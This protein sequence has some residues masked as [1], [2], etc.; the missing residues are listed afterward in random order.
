MKYMKRLSALLLLVFLIMTMIPS[1]AIAENRQYTVRVYAGNQGAFSGGSK[2]YTDNTSPYSRYSQNVTTVTPNKGY[3]VK[4]I[5]ES[6]KDQLLGGYQMVEDR[7]YVVAYGI[8]GNEVKYT[9]HYVL[10]GSETELAPPQTFY[11]D[12]GD[13]PVSSYIYIDG[14]QPYRRT[15]RTI[16]LDESQNVLYAYYT[17]ITTGTTGGGG[18]ITN[19]T[20]GGGGVAAGGNAAN[21]NTATANANAN[22]VL[23]QPGYQMTEDI[24]DLDVPLAEFE[25]PAASVAPVLVPFADVNGDTAQRKIPT[26]LTIALIVLLA[27]LIAALYWYLLFYRKKKKYANEVDY[28]FSFLDDDDHDDYR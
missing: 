17:R 16:G 8:E 20:T 1:E 23:P 28:D 25:G 6:G 11:A 18:T 7:D 2:V 19:V 14:Y 26:G 4:G 21:A 22:S 27:G 13:R 12:P 24:L 3:Y 15:T 10:Y 9:V 5:K